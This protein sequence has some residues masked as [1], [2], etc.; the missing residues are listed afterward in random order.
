MI[1]A[2]L[3]NQTRTAE[4]WASFVALTVPH[5]HAWWAAAPNAAHSVAARK[6]MEGKPAR[7]GVTLFALATEL[8]R[9]CTVEVQPR[10]LA[11]VDAE[12]ADVEVIAG[13]N[14]HGKAIFVADAAVA[15]ALAV[16]NS[17]AADEVVKAA[18]VRFANYLAG[19]VSAADFLAR[20]VDGTVLAMLAVDLA[21][22]HRSTSWQC[23]GAVVPAL[24]RSLV[25]DVLPAAGSARPIAVTADVACPIHD[26]CARQIGRLNLAVLD[27]DAVTAVAKGLPQFD[28]LAAQRLLRHL[29]RSASDQKALQIPDYRKVSFAHGW[30]GLAEC[31]GDRR[32]DPAALQELLYAG[33]SVHWTVNGYE[34]GGLWTFRAV[35]GNA[36]APG[37]VTIVVGE[38]LAPHFVLA[39]EALAANTDT[40]RKSRR[41]VP[42]LRYEPPVLA[43]RPNERG[44]AWLLHRRLLVEFVDRGPDLFNR[45]SVAIS[46]ALWTEMAREVGL[47]A[48]SVSR[49]VDSWKS[50]ESEEAPALVIEPQPEHYTLSAAHDVE[51]G[52]ILEGARRRIQGRKAAEIGRRAKRR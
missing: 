51:L 39:S 52:F 5:L 49:L 20:W 40:A 30:R 41:L 47:P 50:G 7:G 29:V 31:I 45:G 28:T 15:A 38:A 36:H 43:L 14:E 21:D 23:P 4:L 46:P 1:A 16:A 35:R 19:S 34:Y 12:Q 2:T 44:K 27:C 17:A 25:V 24:A 42:E 48:S 11:L 8:H 26:R 13:A 33:Q 22:S 18:S 3:Q 32:A 6:A 37:L 10:I 9:L